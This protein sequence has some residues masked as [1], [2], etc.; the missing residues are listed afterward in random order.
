MQLLFL[1]P[2][3]VE[4]ET[5]LRKERLTQGVGLSNVLYG[6]IISVLVDKI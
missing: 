3:E 6:L 2:G 4:L 1:L 5:L